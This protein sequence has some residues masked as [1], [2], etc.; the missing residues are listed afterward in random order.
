LHRRALLVTVA[1]VQQPN[2]APA[3]KLGSDGTPSDRISLVHPPQSSV[4]T[5][6]GLTLESPLSGWSE[7]YAAPTASELEQRFRHQGWA[8][9]RQQVFAALARTCQ[10]YKRRDRFSCCGSQLSLGVRADELVLSCWHCEDR[11][12]EPCQEDKRKRLRDRVHIRCDE[13]RGNVRFFTFTLRHSRTPLRAQI[14]R[15][16]HSLRTL[17]RRPWW[18]AHQRGGIDCIEQK[19]SDKD[20]L[21]HVHAHCLVEGDWIDQHEL[22]RVWH[23]I[24][25]DSSVVDVEKKGTA[26]QMARYAT[27]Y[28]T[29]PLH[30]S[31]YSDADKLDEA[32]CALKGVRL[33]SC[34]GTWHGLDEDEDEP[35]EPITHHGTIKGLIGA[36]LDGDAGARLWLQLA[37]AKWPALEALV[38][39]AALAPLPAPTPLA[40]GPPPPAPLLQT[41]ELPF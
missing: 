35:T 9:R 5:S 41:E 13:A 33:V 25:G 10:P 12:C 30:S 18:R 29:K 21:W 38:P 36:S 15:L 37:C 8:W 34:W 6:P 31:V 16:K 19:I 20:G 3:I 1:G 22:S 27:K 7:Q 24:T 14:D 32:C 17:H 39:T 23:E 4:P 26:E 40:D 2:Q 28:A 11:L